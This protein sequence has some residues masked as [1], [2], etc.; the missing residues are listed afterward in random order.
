MEKGRL[1]HTRTRRHD[2]SAYDL[3]LG[4]EVSRCRWCA[5]AHSRDEQPPA[6]QRHALL[7]LR[8]QCLTSETES[9]LERKIELLLHVSSARSP[10][11]VH[12]AGR[13]PRS[14]SQPPTPTSAASPRAG[15]R[16]AASKLVGAGS[17]RR[18]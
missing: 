17:P 11:V 18:G 6:S 2:G 5:G 12:G 10:A 16:A 9:K 15:L 8:G 14:P 4:P 7:P 3:V 1:R 13:G